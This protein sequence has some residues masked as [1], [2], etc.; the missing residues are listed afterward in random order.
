M[1]VKTKLTPKQKKLISL[2]PLVEAGEITKTEALKRAGYADSTAREQ[3]QVLGNLGNNKAMQE[4][5]RKHGVTEETIA[6]GIRDGLG[7]IEKG[8]PDFRA[9]SIFVKIGAELLDAFPSQKHQHEII[10]PTTYS[11]LEQPKAKSPEDAR[12]M[13]ESG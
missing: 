10:Q 4:A 5:L 12:R 6:S 1:C 9:R 2:L 13:A 11:D 8:L 7:A 3:Q